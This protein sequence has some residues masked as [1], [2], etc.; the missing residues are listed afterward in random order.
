MSNEGRALR[1][2]G[3][4][5]NGAHDNV[6]EEETNGAAVLERPGSTEEETGANDTTNAVGELARV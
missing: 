5:Y 4:T 6:A 3:V 1:W 2:S